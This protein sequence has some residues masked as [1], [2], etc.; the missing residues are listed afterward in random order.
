MR[1]R[2]ER[3][4]LRTQ[5]DSSIFD[6]LKPIFF[7]R[8]GLSFYG[9]EKHKIINSNVGATLKYKIIDGRSISIKFID[10]DS[11]LYL[12]F[13]GHLSGTLGPEKCIFE[14]KTN[15]IYLTN[16]TSCGVNMPWY[17]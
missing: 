17:L 10:H 7:D 2:I 5:I 4:E 6:A 11:L 16:D 14:I 12:R 8:V 1:K 9:Y 15:R 13:W 3:D